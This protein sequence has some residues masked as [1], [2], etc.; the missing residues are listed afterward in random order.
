MVEN[1]TVLPFEILRSVDRRLRRHVPVDLAAAG[2]GAADDP[3]RRTFGEHADGTEEARCDADLGA[4]RDHRLLRLAAAVGVEDVQLE[5]VLLEQPGVVADLGDEGLA[6]AAP[7]DRDLEP[8]L[9]R[10]RVGRERA[11]GGEQYDPNS[12]ATHMILP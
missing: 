5:L 1:A 12:S 3:H 8:V 2:V 6:D 4:V 9:R 10:H 7:A 11:D